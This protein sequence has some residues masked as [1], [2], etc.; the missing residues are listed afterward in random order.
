MPGAP[1]TDARTTGARPRLRD[2][3]PWFNVAYA[4]SFGPRPLPRPSIAEVRPMIASDVWI[5]A[6]A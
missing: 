1:I 2:G 5:E 4:G 6:I 3:F